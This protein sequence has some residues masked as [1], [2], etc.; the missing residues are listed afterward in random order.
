[1][2]SA[3]GVDGRAARHPLIFDEVPTGPGSLAALEASWQKFQQLLGERRQT[4]DEFVWS[5]TNRDP[6]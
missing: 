6:R 3:G 4:Y 2:G 1:M 5:L